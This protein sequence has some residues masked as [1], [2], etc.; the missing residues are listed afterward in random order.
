[1]TN[2]GYSFHKSNKKQKK[3]HN[4]LK[5]KAQKPRFMPIYVD[6]S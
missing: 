1:M 2:L 3:V 5:K 6:F 4:L